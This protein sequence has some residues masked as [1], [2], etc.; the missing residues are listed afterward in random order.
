MHTDLKYIIGV[1]FQYGLLGFLFISSASVL[2]FA[3]AKPVGVGFSGS[4]ALDVVI[5]TLLPPMYVTGGIF[6][7][8]RA[9]MLAKL[10]PVNQMDPG[11]NRF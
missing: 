1:L 9:L 10:P 8:I 4:G 11:H 7:L 2:A 3:A 5:A 6:L